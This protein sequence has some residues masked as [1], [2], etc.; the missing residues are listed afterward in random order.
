ML[1]GDVCKRKFP[2]GTTQTGLT[3]PS[4]VGPSGSDLVPLRVRA[5]LSLGS[6]GSFP[7][8]QSPGVVP[9]IKGASEAPACVESAR[10]RS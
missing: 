9:G 7:A 6:S 8:P 4:R 10:V 2:N 5:A 1:I 3:L